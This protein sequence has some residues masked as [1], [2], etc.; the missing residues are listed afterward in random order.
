MIYKSIFIISVVSM[1]LQVAESCFDEEG[2]EESRLVFAYKFG[3]EKT[4]FVSFG[5]ATQASFFL[6]I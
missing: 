6:C 1:Y 5:T 4:E 3:V 2:Y